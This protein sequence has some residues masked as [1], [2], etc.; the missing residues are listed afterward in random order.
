M[1]AFADTNCLSS[2][3]ADKE[4]QPRR[5]IATRKRTSVAAV[6]RDH[7]RPLLSGK[8]RIN[9]VGTGAFR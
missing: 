9:H 5:N 6:C 1:I 3:T 2:E 4:G 7:H 8:P